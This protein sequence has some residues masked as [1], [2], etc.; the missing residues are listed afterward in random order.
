MKLNYK[1]EWELEDEIIDNIVDEVEETVNQYPDSNIDDC[2]SEITGNILGEMDP[3]DKCDLF[4]TDAYIND[5]IEEVKHK[6]YDRKQKSAI[7]VIPAELHS[8]CV[9]RVDDLGRIV[10]PKE[11]RIALN[12]EDGEPFEMF[13]DNQGHIILKKYHG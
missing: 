11:Y 3:Y 9:R 7:P 2:I 6:Y 5:V 10:I 4:N 12:I 13:F 8:G 1:V